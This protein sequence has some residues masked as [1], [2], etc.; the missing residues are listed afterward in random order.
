MLRRTISLWSPLVA[1]LL[2]CPSVWSSYKFKEEYFIFQRH[3]SVANC[4][5]HLILFVVVLL[6]TI[7]RLRFPSIIKL[8]DWVLGSKIALWH[9]VIMNSCLFAESMICVRSF[10]LAMVIIALMIAPLGNL[11][12]PAAAL[13]IGLAVGRLIYI[14]HKTTIVTMNKAIRRTFCD[15][16]KSFM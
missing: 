5:V 11:Q 1:L 14:Y 3:R 4:I 9:R 16:S 10:N 8:A 2:I 6:L 12:I 7:S 13:R 15:L